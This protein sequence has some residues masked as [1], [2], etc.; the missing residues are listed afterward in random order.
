M[1]LSRPSAMRNPFILST[2]P[3]AVLTGTTFAATT[4]V[5]K[6]PSNLTVKPVGVNSFK[7]AWKDNSN[8]ETGFEILVALKGGKPARFILLP[9]ANATSYTLST[10]NNELP[11]KDLLFQVRAY[12][13]V[14]GKEQFSKG[15]TIVTATA[16]PS[17]TFGTPTK[18]TAKTIDDGQIVV[19]WKDNATS[20]NGY[21][22][23]Y[24]KSKDK[25]WSSLGNA[26]PDTKFSVPSYG[27]EPLTR[28]SFRVR[29]Y[30]GN[31]GVATAYSNVAET[32]TLKFQAPTKFAASA[33]EDG[34]FTF[35]WSDN[36][37]IEQGYELEKR[38]GKKGA[39]TVQ[40]TVPA[41]TDKTTPVTGFAIKADYQFRLR[42]FR[43]V[44]S[45]RVYT[46][47]S[48]TVEIRSS[49]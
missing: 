1:S 49:S 29:A 41:N 26:Q 16:L 19:S 12:N 21:S 34:A 47:Y 36:S 35:K 18:L 6:A 10:V 48:K 24:K 17:S 46:G 20:E 31:P 15:T 25:N 38:I 40:G 7:L 44:D 27:Y 9:S 3:F 11:K 14:A 22:M 4:P 37:S 32:T 5:P 39:F 30:K 42:G 13:G 33:A 23:E 45:K 2:I 8:N 43:T 28:Y